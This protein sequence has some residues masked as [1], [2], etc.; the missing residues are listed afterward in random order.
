MK[1]VNVL[2]LCSF[3]ILSA[4]VIHPGSAIAGRSTATCW[5]DEMTPHTLWRKAG[6][7][8]TNTAL[9]WMELIYQPYYMR[10]EG[11]QLPVAII[12]GVIKGVFYGVARTLVGVYDTLT[13]PVPVPE[14]YK[15][16]MQP[17]IAI[18]G[19]CTQMYTERSL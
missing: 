8:I 9:G 3:L 18:P 11:N 19:Y 12:G 10:A 15:P 6:R 16:I 14:E 17:E 1:K 5:T 2:V 7:G 13:F 4:A